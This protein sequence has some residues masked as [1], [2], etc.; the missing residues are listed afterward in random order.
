LTSEHHAGTGKIIEAGF[1]MEY[2]NAVAGETEAP[3][4]VPISVAEEAMKPRTIALMVAAIVAGVAVHAGAAWM[5]FRGAADS[6]WRYAQSAGQE[7]RFND[8]FVGDDGAMANLF[9][10]AP[11]PKPCT[12]EEVQALRGPV[13]PARDYTFSGPF[14]HANL[15]VYLI[16]G[17]DTLKDQKVLTLQQALQQNLVTVHEGLVTVDNRAAVPVFIQAGDIIKGGTQDR[18]LPYDLLIPPNTQGLSVAAF[19]VEAGRSGPRGQELSTAFEMAT[20]QL[21]G[22]QLNLAARDRHSQADVWQ[23]V[24]ETQQALTR[25]LGGS[26]QAPQSQSSLQLTLESPR[27]HQA[28]QAYLNELTV[29]PAGKKN[30]IGVAVAV[31]GRIQSAEVYASSDLFLSLWPKLLKASAVAAIAERQPGAAAAPPSREVLQRFLTD[32]ETG[33]AQQQE[34]AGRTMLIRQEA[35]QS[36]LFDTCDPAHQNLVLHRSVLAR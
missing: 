22:K 7:V 12:P 34:M 14:Q 6:G 32:A 19:C 4:G 23:G 36:L 11:A 13:V 26:V 9:P 8:F 17:P 15:A 27:V 25:T 35:G 24:Q 29:A 1:L 28:V 18:V 20:E 3:L 2:T 31:N 10:P 21:P 16:H 30:V 33:Q 5:L